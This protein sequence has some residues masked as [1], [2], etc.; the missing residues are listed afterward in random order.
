MGQADRRPCPATPRR[1]T[2]AFRID[3]TAPQITGASFTPGGATLPL[4]NG[5]QPNITDVPTL[6]TLSLNVD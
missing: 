3:K 2:D 4:P 6:T 5:P 1:A